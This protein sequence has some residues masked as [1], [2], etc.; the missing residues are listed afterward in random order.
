M[1]Q[2]LGTLD[3]P[4]VVF[5]GPYSNL[6]ATHALLEVVRQRGVPFSHVICTGDVVAYCAHPEAT[7][8]AVCDIGIAVVAGNCERQLGASADTCGC[9]FEQGT[10]CDL[11][12]PGWYAYANERVSLASRSWMRSLP[13]V[14]SFRHQGARYAVVHGGMTDIARF[15]WPDASQGVFAQEL[16]A[17][18]ARVGAVD[19]VIAGH[20]GLPF[21]RQTGQGRWIN[22]G[23]IGMPPNDGR[24]Q[25]RFAVLDGGEVLFHHLRYDAEAAARDMQLAGLTHGYDKALLSGYWP[26][27]DMLPSSLRSSSFAKG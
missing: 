8:Q 11:L 20:C 25:T 16:E 26:S 27:E 23:V 3:G 21:I 9:G 10:T 13:D 15:I 18:R 1:H 24:Q 22:A 12:S 5:G 6:Q 4:V 19:H 2:D 17:V 14:V 7:A